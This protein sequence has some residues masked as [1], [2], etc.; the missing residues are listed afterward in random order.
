[1]VLHLEYL[2]IFVRQYYIYNCYLNI[3]DIYSIDKFYK[4]AITHYM[5]AKEALH[6]SNIEDIDIFVPVQSVGGEIVVNIAVIAE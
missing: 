6:K 5:F 1:M 2:S 3:A 4:S